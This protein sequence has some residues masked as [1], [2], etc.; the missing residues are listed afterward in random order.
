MEASMS[1]ADLGTWSVEL[2]QQRSRLA[3]EVADVLR[4]QIIT[5][6]LGQGTQLL[7]IQLSERLGVSRTPLREAFRILERD[8]LVKISNGN[9]TI[10]VAHLGV[11][12]LL[13]TYEVRAVTDGLAARLTAVRGLPGHLDERFADC[14]Q[15]MEEASAGALSPARYAEA[16]ATWHLLLLEASGNARLEDCARLVRVSSHMLITRQLSDAERT[17]VRPVVDSLVANGNDDHKRIL[18]AIREHNA[19][20]AE[21]SAIRH[22]ERSVRFAREVLARRAGQADRPPNSAAA[23][24]RV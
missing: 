21:R 4:K 1:V 14:T 20:S 18:E 2:Q 23:P 24:E 9:K 17:A 8:G 12:D 13:A 3:D 16:H 10:E 7:Q 15:T 6:E 19:G 11:A 22:V 5:G